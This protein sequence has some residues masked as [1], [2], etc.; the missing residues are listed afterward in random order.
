MFRTAGA[1]IGAVL[2]WYTEET[3]KLR[4]TRRRFLTKS[5]GTGVG[6]RIVASGL[7]NG[8]DGEDGGDGGAGISGLVAGKRSAIGGTGNGTRG[9]FQLRV[10]VSLVHGA[11]VDAR[12]SGAGRTTH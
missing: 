6:A 3:L 10:R 9:C 11:D 8:E 1:Q 7:L 2:R 5:G 12:R 4:L